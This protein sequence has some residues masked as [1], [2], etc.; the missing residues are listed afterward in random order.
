MYIKRKKIRERE[1]SIT[2]G[3]IRDGK[4]GS[5]RHFDLNEDRD[6]DLI[7]TEHAYLN[8]TTRGDLSSLRWYEAQH[9]YLANTSQY[10]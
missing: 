8:V 6:S 4:L 1:D 9:K 2:C 5:F 3:C 7:D 10:A